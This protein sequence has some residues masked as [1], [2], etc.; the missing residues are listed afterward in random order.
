MSSELQIRFSFILRIKENSH[1]H[2]PL[3]T[4][5]KA[6]CTITSLQNRTHVA[7]IVLVVLYWVQEPVLAVAHARFLGCRKL[8]QETQALFLHT[9][10]NLV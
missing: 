10:E 1:Y 7:G 5:Q 2:G 8:N 3:I 9:A 6:R 4:S